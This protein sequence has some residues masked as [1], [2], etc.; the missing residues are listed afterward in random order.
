MKG[1]ATTAPSPPDESDERGE[2]EVEVEIDTETVVW[3]HPEAEQKNKS[4][5]IYV[6]DGAAT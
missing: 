4:D 5:E 6:D 3:D 2:A 1:A